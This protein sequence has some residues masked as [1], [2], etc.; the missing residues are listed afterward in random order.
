MQLNK[1]FTL[2]ELLIVVAIIG[3]LAAIAVPN[4]LNAQVRAKIAKVESEMKSIDTALESYRLDNNMYPVW[5]TFQG[6]N[7]WPVSKRLA[8]LTTPISY[9]SSVPQDPFL[10]RIHGARLNED[11]H[12]A[13]D[14]YDYVDAWTAFNT[15]KA[16]VLSDSFRCSEWRLASAGPD[17]T[18]TYGSVAAF[19]VSNGVNSI[20]DIV[21]TGPRV[22]RPCDASLVGK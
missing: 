3:I 19:N 2:I 6:G 7:I 10:V 15:S 14:T 22:S 12:E 4:F 16:T 5:L 20:G 11:Q 1:A 21:R 17:G 8:P 13:Y 9:I 18:Q